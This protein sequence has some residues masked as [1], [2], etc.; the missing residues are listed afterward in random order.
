MKKIKFL[1]IAGLMLL[2]SMAFAQSIEV[3]DQVSGSKIDWTNGKY[4]AV[5]MGAVAPRNEQPNR[6]IAVLKAKDYAKME[7]LANLLMLIEGTKI[8]YESTGSDYM[9]DTIIKQK[10]TGFVNNVTIEEAK[11]VNVEGD[12]IIVVKCVSYMYGVNQNSQ[13]PGAVLLGKSLKDEKTIFDSYDIKDIKQPEG[14]SANDV[15]VIVAPASKFP[16]VIN[17][18][19][20]NT[21]PKLDKPVPYK[22]A[23]RSGNEKY[24]G[25]IFDATGFTLDR[26]M[27]PKVRLDNGDIVWAGANCDADLAI[28]KGIC[29]YVDSLEA[30]KKNKRA[31]SNP[32]VIS[33]INVAGKG[34]VKTDVIIT[35]VDAE[36]LKD[37]NAKSKFLD[38]LNVVIVKN[39]GI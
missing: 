18:P 5:G 12:E 30:A 8:D 26:S 6:A 22:V 34:K 25:V 29:S 35:G 38:N 14:R 4:I 24:T 20:V 23:V 32:L 16:V 3:L 21:E 17:P 37:E 33:V 13:N 28:S 36:I 2:T 1:L 39:K 10:I 15:P 27:S 19:S 31:G 7:A 11:K 9:A